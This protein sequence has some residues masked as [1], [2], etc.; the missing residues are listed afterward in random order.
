MTANSTPSSRASMSTSR[1]SPR[2]RDAGLLDQ[3]V[4]LALAAQHVERAHVI[5]VDHRERPA[6]LSLR[7][8]RAS[9]RGSSSSNTRRVTR[10]V[11]VSRQRQR[12]ASRARSPACSI[13]TAA[14]AATQPQ[15]AGRR[16]RQ[17]L[18]RHLPDHDQ[19]AG[20]LAV[21][22]HR[23]EDR[24]AGARRL[25]QR[26]RQRRV[27][28]RVGDEVGL[29][30]GERAA[31]ARRRRRA[32]GSSP[33]ATLDAG[34]RGRHEV[35][36]RTARAGTPPARPSTSQAASQIA[37]R[38]SSPPASALATR[39]IAPIP[40]AWSRSMS[41]KRRRSRSLDSRSSSDASTRA[42]IVKSCS[43]AAVNALR[44]SATARPASRRACRRRAPAARRGRTRAPTR[45]CIGSARVDRVA[46]DVAAAPRGAVLGHVRAERVAERD[47]QVGAQADTRRRCG[48][49]R[50]GG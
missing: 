41:L 9:S 15:H 28:A 34:H 40:R 38:A 44:S 5:E 23:L 31:A 27:V 7:R 11:S 8:A 37:W 35:A 13:A 3:A 10:P 45:C 12:A 1:S 39:P 14:C 4:A 42:S 6:A 2:Q 49:R 25:H 33:A 26:R 20:D 22:Q 48:C 46:A 50:C 19:H 21:A 36:A 29:L 47:R 30:G 17:R 16:L 18:Q 24:R 43:S 32:A